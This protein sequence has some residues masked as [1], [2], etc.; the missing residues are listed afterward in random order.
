MAITRIRTFIAKYHRRVLNGPDRRA[1]RELEQAITCGTDE[2][3]FRE[4]YRGV[5]SLIKLTEWE[6]GY[7]YRPDGGREASEY[8]H[9]SHSGV[10]LTGNPDV[11]KAWFQSAILVDRRLD[12]IPTVLQI[13]FD[14]L[15]FDERGARLLSL[16][17]RSDPVFEDT[18]V[19][20]L[21]DQQARGFAR[22]G[23]HEWLIILTSSL[24]FENKD[25]LGKRGVR[26][27][28]QIATANVGSCRSDWSCC[29][30]KNTTRE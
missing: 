16:L 11:G 18:R 15:L 24:S 10:I 2:M 13:G 19:W 6:N 8:R 30:L 27:D 21:V 1:C 28:H 14:H 17:S 12:G 7:G 5:P 3:V 9:R 23:N 29:A 26:T 22:H 25:F 20:A 4:S